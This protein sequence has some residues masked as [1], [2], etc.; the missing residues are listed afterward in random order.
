MS[1]FRGEFFDA[2]GVM[3]K[4]SDD[5][6]LLDRLPITDP[7]N[8]S[9]RILRHGLAVSAFALLE[10]Y[11]KS[12]FEELVKEVA[13]SALAYQSLPEKMKKFFTVDSVSGL[14]NK[15]YFIKESLAKLSFV[16]TNL[17]LVASFGAV[18]PVYTSFGFSP[19]GSN[20]GH[21]D[22]K[23]GFAS[24]SVNNAWGKLD[25]IARQIGAASLS[26][27]NDYKA[28]AQARHSSAH[29]P[30]G[31]IP[32]GTLQSSIRSGIVIGIAADIL[33]CD[34]GKIIRGTSNTQSLDAK[35]NSVTHRVRFIDEL[36]NG[37]WVERPT[38][39]S[40]AIK[41][42]PDRPSAKAGVLA[43]KSLG[44]VVARGISTSPLELFS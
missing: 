27:E 14:S 35:V 17:S 7:H 11:L 10:K 37:A 18:P 23:Q 1:V 5:A 34:V 33:A 32:T 20:V 9:A 42:Y 26:L 30:A 44:M 40:R 2:L 13:R 43:R 3:L 41:K 6:L 19:S 8:V 24:F 16:E 21:E 15:A 22:I 36:A 31:N 4:V 39:A 29:D 38:I 28:L 25:A 12:I